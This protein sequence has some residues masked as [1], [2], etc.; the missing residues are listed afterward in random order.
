MAT[1]RFEPTPAWLH[2]LE[3]LGCL[4]HLL[5]VAIDGGQV[6][7]WCRAFPDL[8]GDSAE[9]GLGLL[10]DF[11]GV[12][13]G[14]TLMKWTVEWAKERGLR[15]LRLSTR[16]DNKRAIH[17]FQK[18]GFEFSGVPQGPEQEMICSL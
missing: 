18:F 10:S 6:V 3:T 13:L 7:G 5:L 11:R 2:A 8:E 17:L 15:T 12:G 4:C 16:P 14:S 9:V 1:R